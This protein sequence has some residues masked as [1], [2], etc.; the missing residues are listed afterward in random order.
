MWAF[1][2][3]RLSSLPTPGS[4]EGLRSDEDIWDIGSIAALF[5]LSNRVANVIALTPNAEFYTMGRATATP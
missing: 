3:A 1:S 2:V 5:A 4:P